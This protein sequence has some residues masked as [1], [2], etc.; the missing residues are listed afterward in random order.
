MNILRPAAL[1]GAAVL[2]LIAP[3]SAHTPPMNSQLMDFPLG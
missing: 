2:T 3:A 1:A